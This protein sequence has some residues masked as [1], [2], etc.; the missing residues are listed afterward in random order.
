MEKLTVNDEAG[1]M[2]A[3]QQFIQ[4]LVNTFRKL[5]NGELQNVPLI[6]MCLKLENQIFL[7]ALEDSGMSQS[8]NVWSNG[9]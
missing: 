8:S 6:E 1:F 9:R 2:L 3:S 7:N 4:K 5:P